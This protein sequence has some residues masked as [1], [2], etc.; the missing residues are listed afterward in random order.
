MANLLTILTCRTAS[1]RLPG[2]ALVPIRSRLRDGSYE[3]QPLIVWIIRRLKKIDGMLAVATT[4]EDTDTELA[5]VCRRENVEVIRGSR[6][7]VIDRMHLVIRTNQYPAVGWILRALGDMPFAN[8]PVINYATRRLEETGKEAFVY[9]Q[10]PD[11]YNFLYGSREFPYSLSAFERIVRHS[12]H[13]EHLDQW[14]HANRK[15]FDILYH[16]PIDTTYQRLYRLEVDEK[17]DV[18]VVEA[19]AEEVGMLADV[20][21]I[22]NFLDN[23]PDIV[24]INSGYTE[25][26]GITNLNTY[27]NAQ[28]RAWLS[29]MVGKPVMTI[30]GKWLKPPSPKA[31][32]IF[33]SCG[34]CV[35]WGEYGRLH[36]KD[37]HIMDVGFPKCNNC[38][39]MVREWK[40]AAPR[41]A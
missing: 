35:G 39:L 30:E 1:E 33:C 38:G 11:C 31:T 17:P 7:D 22:V 23:R 24:R 28:R 27:D 26:T 41:A 14:F 2:K 36:L 32:P 16:Q 19:I 21:T 18:T 9:H 15:S 6:D 13:R 40:K 29:D 3:T 4:N 34:N 37:G 25:K 8:I 10:H 5:K 20:K 12:P